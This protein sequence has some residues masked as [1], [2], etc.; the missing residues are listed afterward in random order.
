VAAPLAPLAVAA[1]LSPLAVAAPLSPLAITPSLLP[2]ATGPSFQFARSKTHWT[3]RAAR[4]P[5]ESSTPIVIEALASFVP[6]RSNAPVC[7]VS[8][9]RLPAGG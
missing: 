1:P 7:V 5:S 4:S 6:S 8:A 9:K 2:V 3:A